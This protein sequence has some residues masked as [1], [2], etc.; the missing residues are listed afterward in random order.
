[1]YVRHDLV[2]YY[3]LFKKD[4]DATELSGSFDFCLRV[5]LL[6]E[7][8]SSSSYNG[9]MNSFNHLEESTLLSVLNAIENTLKMKNLLKHPG[10]Y[11]VL[12][13]G[14]GKGV[15]ESDMEQ[16]SQYIYDS[17]HE[18]R[19]KSYVWRIFIIRELLA[20]GRNSKP[21]ESNIICLIQGLKE[22]VIWL[23]VI[24]TIIVI[25]SWIQTRI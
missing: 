20:W 17:L 8:N 6:T 3:K 2:I 22:A 24:T 19:D 1:M 18:K 15:S 11:D 10:F 21:K 7:F 5:D 16:L 12:S 14:Y 25:I 4:K 23:V 9:K 13:W